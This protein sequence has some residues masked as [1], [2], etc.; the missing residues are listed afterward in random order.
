MEPQRKR[1]FSKGLNLEAN[2]EVRP[3]A[4]GML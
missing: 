1:G 2:P 4:S 3:E